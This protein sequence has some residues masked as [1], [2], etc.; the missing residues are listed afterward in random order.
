MDGITCNADSSKKIPLT[1]NKQRA[2]PYSVQK[3]FKHIN[4]VFNSNNESN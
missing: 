1:K 3:I 2:K 4:I